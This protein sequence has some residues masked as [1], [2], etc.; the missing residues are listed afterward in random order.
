MFRLT[1]R[2]AGNSLRVTLSARAA[3]AL[4][5]KAGDKLL[6]TEAPGG[7]RITPYDPNFAATMNVAERFLNR[8]RN[9]L[10][11]LAK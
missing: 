4:R 10:R 1:V 9:A 8:Y 2:K 11:N 6:L 7:F 3:R 5:V